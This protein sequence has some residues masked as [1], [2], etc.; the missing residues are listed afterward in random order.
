MTNLD[1]QTAFAMPTRYSGMAIRKGRGGRAISQPALSMQGRR[2]RRNWAGRCSE[3]RTGGVRAHGAGGALRRRRGEVLRV[4]TRRR[5]PLRRS[6]ARGPVRL[7]CGTG[8]SAAALCGSGA[9]WARW[10]QSHL[11]WRLTLR[12]TITPRLIRDLTKGRSTRPRW[13]CRVRNRGDGDGA[14]E[15][16]PAVRPEAGRRPGAGPRGGSGDAGLPASRGGALLRARR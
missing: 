8:L 9:S 3:A 11:A 5:G 13:P 4:V 2:W 7:A 15:R 10:A 6:R 12:C 14:F 1:P 16:I